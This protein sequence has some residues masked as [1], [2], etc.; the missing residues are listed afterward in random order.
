MAH[1]VDI[2]GCDT[3]LPAEAIFSEAF[4]YVNVKYV[5]PATT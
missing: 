5:N 1:T 3:A 4:P 2:A